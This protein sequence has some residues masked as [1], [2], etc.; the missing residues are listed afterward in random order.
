MDRITAVI[1]KN[2]RGKAVQNLQSALLLLLAHEGGD[3]NRQA[4]LEQLLLE[5]RDARYGEATV[6]SVAEFQSTHHLDL[7]SGQQVDTATADALNRELSRLSAFEPTL[8]EDYIVTG[9]VEFEDGSPAA[10]MRVEVFDRDL[11]AARTPLGNRDNQVVTGPDGAFSAIRYHKRDFAEKEGNRNPNPDLVFTVS[12][13]RDAHEIVAIY[14]QRNTGSTTTEL[15]S[16]DLVLGFSAGLVEEIRIVLRG[17]RNQEGTE[18]TELLG[19]LAPLLTSTPAQL[20]QDQHRDFDFAA[21]ETGWDAHLIGL[22]YLSWTLAEQASREPQS[23]A[24]TFYGLLRDGPPVEV[25]PLPAVL[26]ELL[27]RDGDWSVKLTDS[28]KHRVISGALDDH[29][30]RLFELQ[31]RSG[32]Q[33]GNRRRGTVGDLLSRAGIPEEDRVTLLNEYGKHD[34]TPEAFWRDVVE[35]RMGWDRNRIRA[36]QSLLQLADLTAYDMALLDALHEHGVHTPRDLVQLDERQ[37]AE[38]VRGVGPSDDVAGHDME[39]RVSRTVD[40]ILSVAEAMYPTAVMAQIVRSSSDPQLSAAR[41]HL[42]RFFQNESDFDIASSPVTAYLEEHGDRIGRGMHEED[43]ALLTRQLQRLQRVFRLGVDRKQTEAL[44]ASN[45][46]SA[47]RITRFSPEHFV[48]EF[49]DRLGGEERARTTYR[50]AESV[51]GTILYLYTDLWTGG[52]AVSPMAI[53]SAVPP[54]VLPSIK[55]VPAF[56]DL[57]GSLQMCECGHCRSFYSPSAYFVDLLHMIDRPSLAPDNPADV[58]FERRPD[59]AHIQLTC[60]NTNTLIPYVDLVTE[61]LESFV[62]NKV[63]VAFNMPPAPPN[64]NLPSPSAE[65]LR[66]NPVYLTEA[67]SKF[68][69]QAYATVQEAVFPLGLPLNLPLETT[70]LYLGHLG[71]SRAELMPLLD[72]D[73]GL[74]PLMA[75]AAEILSLS[76][77]EFEIVS[78]ST[79]GGASSLR[80]ETV[81][82]FFGFSTGPTPAALFNH[83]EPEFVRNPANPDRR[84]SL[85]R[86]LQN[87]LSVY[88]PPPIPST[89]FG[90]YEA[91]TEAAVN[92]VLTKAGLPATGR[93]DGAFWGAMEAQGW[94]PVSVLMCPV[95]MFLSRSGLTYEELIA[96]VQTRFVNPRLQGDGDFD[97]LFRLG[98]PTEDVRVWIEAGFPPLPAAIT[99]QLAA[100]GENPVTFTDWVKRRANAVVINTGFEQPCDMDRATL[101]HL[102]GTLLSPKELMTL[103]RFIRLWKKLGWTLDE[104]DLALEHGS[105]ESSTVFETILLL[106]N[107]KRLHDR[108]NMPIAEVISLW[109]KIPTFGSSALYDRLFR[110]KAAQLIN[111]IFRL[112]D[113]RTE[114]AAA[115]SGTPPFLSEHKELIL[116]AFRLSAQELDAIRDAVGLSDDPTLPPTS[117]PQL[118]LEHLSAIFRRVSLARALQISVR[119]LL[120]LEALFDGVLFE[121]PDRFP[122][123]NALA[124]TDVV[125]KVRASGVKVRD[126][127]YLCRHVPRFPSQPG[128]QPDD[129]IRTLAALLNGLNG[130][131]AEEPLVQDSDGVALTVALTSILGPDDAKAT[132]ALIYGTISYTAALA[133]LS[134]TF[135]FPVSLGKKVRYDATRKQLQSRGA[136][137]STECATLLGAAGVPSAVQPDFDRAAKSLQTQP[138]AFVARA[139]KPLFAPADAEALL[140][141]VSSLKSDGTPVSSAIEGKVEEILSR[142]RVVMSR[143]LIKQVISAATELPTDMLS[144]LLENKDVLKSTAGTGPAQDDFEHLDGDGLSA[145]YFTNSTLSGV[146]AVQRIDE[147]PAFAWLGAA[148]APGVPPTGFSVRWTGHIYV[149]AAGD[150]SFRIRCT[151]GVRLVVND[152]LVIDEWRDQ[153]ESEFSGTLRLVGAQ[154]YPITLEYYNKTGA[155]QIT[156]S[157]ASPAIPTTLV[158]RAVLY[159]DTRFEAL[160]QRVERMY[161]I[162]TLL[163]PFKLASRDLEG[164]ARRGDLDLA[165]I[166]LNTPVA[167]IIARK[168]FAQWLVL[169]DFSGLRD[170]F[171]VSDVLLLDVLEAP[172]RAAAINAFVKFSGADEATISSIIDVFTIPLFDPVSSTWSDSPL[173]LTKLSSWVSIAS[174]LTLLMKIGAP[175]A[176]LLAWA[177]TREIKQLPTG[178]ETSW[179]FWRAQ[180]EAKVARSTENSASAQAAKNVVRARYDEQRWKAEASKLNDLL[181]MRRRSALIGF[182]LA[183]PEMMQANVIDNNRLFEYLLIDVEMD[184]CMQ[185]SRIKQ[186]ISSVQLFI[187]RVLLDLESP[188]V[189]PSR[190]DRQRWDW[191]KNYRVW[192]ANRKVLLYAESY[193]EEAL[194]DDKTPIFREMESE[195]LQDELNEVNAEKTFRH[196]LEKLDG[197]SKLTVCGVCADSEK[198][199]LHVFART[200]TAPYVFYHRRLDSSSRLS[201]VEGVWSPWQKLP[202][203]VSTFDDGEFSGAHLAPVIWNRRL[204]LFWPIFEQRQDDD[205]NAS[206]PD[207]FPQVSLWRIKLAWA[208]YKDG[209]WS[210]KKTGTPFLIS[211]SATMKVQSD[212]EWTKR[213]GP[214]IVHHDAWVEERLEIPPGSWEPPPGNSNYEQWKKDHTVHIPHDAWD[215]VTPNTISDDLFLDGTTLGQYDWATHQHVEKT[216]TIWTL[217]P[218][219][220]HHFL[221][222][223]ISGASLT[224]TVYCRFS[225]MADGQTRTTTTDTIAVVRDGRRTDRKETGQTDRAATKEAVRFSFSLGNFNFPACNADLA[226]NSSVKQLD[227]NLPERPPGTTNWYQGFIRE[228]LAFGKPFHPLSLTD[229]DPPILRSVSMRANLIDSDNRWGFNRSIPFF[230][231]DQKRCYLV[232]RERAGYKFSRAAIEIRPEPRFLL[233]EKAVGL[234]ALADRQMS[235]VPNDALHVHPW[236]ASAL[237]KWA[238]GPALTPSLNEPVPTRT[239]SGFTGISEIFKPGLDSYSKIGRPE[240]LF[241]THWHP[242]TCPFLAALNNGGLPAL[243]SVDIESQSDKPLPL[244]G[245]GMSKA[246]FET[247]YDPDPIQVKQP[248]PLE[249]VDFGRTGAYAKYNNELFFHAPMTFAAANCAAGKHEAALTWFHFIFDPMTNDPTEGPKR[250]WRYLPFRQNDDLTRIDETLGLL[251]YT[252]SDPAMLKQKAELQASIQEWLDYPFNPH[253]LARRRPVIYMKYVFMKYL[254]NIIA[255]GDELF[256]RDT[257]ESINQATQLYVLAANLLGPRLEKATVP[258]TVAA[259]TY[260]DLRGKL[261]E[262]SNVQVE[263]ETR[264]PFTE[265]FGPPSGGTT[266]LSSL[267]STAYFCIPQNDK[268]LAY[269]DTIADRLFKIRHC[270]NFDGTVRELPLFEPF[271]DP[272]LLVEAVAHGVDIGSVLNDLYAPL[273]R[274]RFPYMIQQALGMC[275]EVRSL[276][277]LMFSLPEKRD[278]EKL[279]AIRAGNESQVLDQIRTNKKLQIDE[280]V[281]ALTALDETMRLTQGKIDYFENLLAQGLISEENDQLGSLDSSNSRQE[282]GSWLEATAQGLNLIPNVSTSGGATFGGSNLGAAAS[283]M[284]KSYSSDAAS[285]AYR[286]NRAS[287]TGSH[288]RRAEDW[289]FQRD[290][291]KRELRQVERQRAAAAIRKQVTE[292][293]LR[294]H[295]L[296]LEQSRSIEEFLGG[297][298]TNETLYSYLEGNLRAI[299]FQCYKAAYDLA[300]SAERIWQYAVGSTTTFIKYGAWDSSVRGLLAG[301]QLYLQLKQMERAYL[302]QQAREFEI[303]RHVSLLQLDPLALIA[304]KESSACEVDIPEWLFDLDYPGHYFRRLKT[305][306][307]TIPAVVGPYTMLNATL[308]LL[309]SSVR[310]SARV[311]G[312]YGDE[313]NYRP[314]HLPV[315]AVAVSAGQN[316]SGRFQLDLRDEKLLPFEGCGAIS[317]WRLDLP[318]QFRAFDYDTISDVILHLRYTSRR[319]DTLQAPALEAVTKTL[320]ST[321]AG[322]GVLFRMISLRHEFP[323]EWQLLRTSTTHQVTVM[324]SKERF[325]LLVQSGVVTVLDV[326]AALTLK[327]ARPALAYHATLTPPGG[328]PSIAID[329]L[330]QPGRY[331]SAV[332]AGST[333]GTV[334][335]VPADNEWTFRISA[336]AAIEE[337]DNIKDLFIVL[338]YTVTI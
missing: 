5:R 110:N 249:D 106:A 212:L 175:P 82:E 141:D 257:M 162:A 32:A 48:T 96:L 229:A 148:P 331:R 174:V 277:G 53:K 89:E 227:Y 149:P 79:F 21:R 221:D 179:F 286:A 239:L 182:M 228:R 52:V 301:E 173:D 194:R 198:G 38:I 230:L 247:A 243:F 86:S 262:L 192:E 318:P 26:G 114:L 18:Y 146:P 306:S 104:M 299:Y 220:W 338:G 75:Q 54:H 88:A 312:S 214:K 117:R 62:A 137:T 197:V 95:L 276:G 39:E 240:Y 258:G 76:P 185:T 253:M 72:R 58:L 120:S 336:P 116:A 87:I 252:G 91:A 193:T 297:K 273:P 290:Q 144:V 164:L 78:F 215:E 225:G 60:E 156:L 50:R 238:A 180:D 305:V 263:I 84:T 255:W 131:I 332:N 3:A 24:E 22:M 337:V 199:I 304:L 70:R 170:Q 133:G 190:I 68:S 210:T 256:Q 151:D 142:R 157:W 160:L 244:G 42:D 147:S 159:T 23:L 2:D 113:S 28:L 12:S 259:K 200:S 269:W 181:R 307:L 209:Q 67:S 152:L 6:K 94:P 36:L 129:R 138:R 235:L 51:V 322:P 155:A 63:P 111:P 242:F 81:P 311:N 315:E 251:T 35:R 321:A 136:L 11:G 101:M 29:L 201:W 97:Y 218:K 267:P 233:R 30:S 61:V 16:G 184:P 69:D 13:Q 245:G 119:E 291:A 222:L 323:I 232:I 85:I 9:R 191:T 17:S 317:R 103:F 154:F 250:F 178:P 195:M 280:A 330:A 300:K 241:F 334:T 327:E 335:L 166:P 108:L 105:L 281:Q 310:E 124:F 7:T 66:V 224:I 64:Q 226:A 169:K 208:E 254:D 333:N 10:G 246:I 265:M 14:R 309:S 125:D 271:I 112:D 132:A 59:L 324:I 236:A 34:G 216:T 4:L 80:P 219:P 73:P 56:H 293:E 93:T 25:A 107:I 123:G 213:F 83:V 223:A 102:D 188:R 163:T 204:Y 234:S 135:V 165:S 284:G 20:D 55:N 205:Q 288:R 217:L 45:L 127:D 270:M 289:R 118:N 43:K 134:P 167:G 203:D 172:D 183:M 140:I 207:G 90:N 31:S 187:Q 77:E 71:I 44:L 99:A 49:G 46:D 121:R 15:D 100:V 302:E 1:L 285:A 264:L 314:D 326:Y 329:W 292:N 122:R 47:F 328:A 278:A 19:D 325:P 126:L 161:K 92:A 206:Q 261:D 139:L 176:Q 283:A 316:E 282:M 153:P 268:L 143:T 202:V 41:D 237:V 109:N 303:T 98:I 320:K 231:Q 186:G 177:R 27:D 158:T 275:N 115:L 168:T 279:A 8:S 319:D 40:S 189:P 260:N 145:H 128:T 248:Y 74:E 272:M 313:Q 295:E 308:T 287:I 211:R 298:F 171:Q 196:Y 130:I 57:F 37:L 33:A 274:Y 65:E 266:T 150:V 294:N 296:Q